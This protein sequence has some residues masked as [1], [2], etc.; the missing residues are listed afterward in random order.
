LFP[1]LVYT[2]GIKITDIDNLKKK[3]LVFI[4]IGLRSLTT[5][6]T[7]DKAAWDKSLTV[8]YT[9]FHINLKYN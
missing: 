6:G 7:V 1:E 4:D 9:W 3:D 5:T 8:Y 2:N